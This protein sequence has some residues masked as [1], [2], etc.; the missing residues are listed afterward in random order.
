MSG[1]GRD[2][3]FF[4]LAT[5]GLKFVGGNTIPKPLTMVRAMNED[6]DPVAEDSFEGGPAVAVEV[7]YRLINSTL[8][9][10]TLSLGY[11]LNGA[12]NLGIV[13]MVFATSNTDWPTL[14]V[15]GFTGVTDFTT[16]PVFTLPSI[17]IS[18]L[19]KAQ[20]FDFAVGAN[21]RLT[22]SGFSATAEFSHVLDGT[23]VVGAM[24]MSGAILE[25]SGEATEIE[26]AVTW[27]P[28]AGYTETQGPNAA[29]AEATWGTGGF[30]ATK[31]LLRD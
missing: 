25:Q 28:G 27:T 23:G 19:K 3:D 26:G 14:K 15:A 7:D 18:G 29:N 4:G 13:S 2:T 20:V 6:G 17:T 10:N 22:S 12:V 5:G 31:L 24:A 8:N 30:G 1:F 9:L 16:M 11:L 21:C